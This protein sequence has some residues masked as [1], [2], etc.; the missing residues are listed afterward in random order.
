MTVLAGA[1]AALG[2][3]RLGSILRAG[4]RDPVT[5]TLVVFSL[6]VYGGLSVQLVR[7]S[8]VRLL[9]FLVVFGLLQAILLCGVSFL[10]AV[11]PK[12]GA[13]K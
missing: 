11:C 5:G 4:G 3:A 6:L 7:R 13:W 12:P 1:T 9:P 2:L 8:P 10:L